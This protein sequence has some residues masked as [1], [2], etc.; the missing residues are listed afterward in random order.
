MLKNLLNG[1]KACALIAA[2]VLPSLAYADHR[3]IDWGKGWDH[4][5]DSDHGRDRDHGKMPPVTV[6]PEANTG[7]VLVP[8]MGVILL[9][10][11][12]RLV[13]ARKA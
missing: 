2:V 6:V 1:C 5:K 13:R 9:V 8:V 7:W 12:V 3:D 11:S 4:G 10:S